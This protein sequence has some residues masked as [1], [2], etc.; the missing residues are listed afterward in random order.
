[1]RFFLGLIL[2]ALLGGGGVYLALQRPWAGEAVEVAEI[3]AGPEM[4]AAEAAPK[5]KSGKGRRGKRAGGVEIQVEGEV[6]ELSAADR[7]LE[8]KG[9]AVSLPSREVDFGSEG[10]GQ[11]LSADQINQVLGGHSQGMVSCITAA[12][13]N[14]QLSATI[15]VKML[16]EGDGRVSK[17]RVHA[18]AYLFA[19]GFYGCARK[20]A[21]ALRFPA[22]GAPTVVEAPY[23]LY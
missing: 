19:H 16:V 11:P 5:K 23:D 13:G 6:P 2:G 9:D 10:G 3:D 17:T 15:I 1:V 8:W 4:V 12:R 20:A 21:R 22:T 14:A 7:K 18:P